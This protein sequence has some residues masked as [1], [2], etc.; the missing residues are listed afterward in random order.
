MRNEIFEGRWVFKHDEMSL[1]Y[2]PPGLYEIG[3]AINYKKLMKISQPELTLLIPFLFEQ[4]YLNQ[5]LNSHNKE[6]NLELT[7]MFLETI[8]K[9]NYDNSNKGKSTLTRVGDS[10]QSSEH[11]RDLPEGWKMQPVLE[12][13]ESFVLKPDNES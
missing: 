1:Y 12:K 9:L 4:G 7:K 3:K 8:E 10:S 11:P 13:T 2:I 6:P 5:F